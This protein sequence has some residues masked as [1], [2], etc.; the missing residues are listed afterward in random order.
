[1]FSI[2][3]LHNWLLPWYLISFWFKIY[4]NMWFN[5][6]QVK[7]LIGEIISFLISLISGISFAINSY[8][9]SD[10]LLWSLGGFAGSLFL[11]LKG[12]KEIRAIKSVMIFWTSSIFDV[13]F[14]FIF[15]KENTE[16]CRILSSL[17]TMITGIYLISKN[18]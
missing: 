14:A 12:M 10:L 18:N 17:L 1:M 16:S 11:F 5:K 6:W 2:L 15:L 3:Y 8:Q 7:S 4:Q 13:I 9:I